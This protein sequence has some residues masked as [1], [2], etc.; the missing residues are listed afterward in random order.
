MYNLEILLNNSNDVCIIDNIG[1][2]YSYKKINTEIDHY[3]NYYG[4]RS[5]ILIISSYTKEFIVQYLSCLKF[6]HA[7][8]I[9]NENIDDELLKKII[10]KYKP[11]YILLR[12]VKKNILKKYNLQKKTKKDV[13][14]IY[15]SI[16]NK[17]IKLNNS[18]ALLLSTSGSTGSLKFVKQTYE[19]INA[20]TKSISKYLNLK[21]N[22]RSVTSLP[23][24]YS[25]GLSV[26]NSHLYIGGSIYITSSNILDT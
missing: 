26:V 13:Y 16:D 4:K 6:G 14:K 5:L 10:T 24:N 11:N 18:L 25:Y 8:I 17:K 22:D 9:L 21:P 19:N 2:K 15:K 23:L 20:N 12:N 7:Q 1:K 3:K